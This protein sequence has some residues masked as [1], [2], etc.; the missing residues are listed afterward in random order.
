MIFRW[1]RE[2]LDVRRKLRN[3]TNHEF[4]KN[5]SDTSKH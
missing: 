5:F 3:M 4:F 1:I 2:R